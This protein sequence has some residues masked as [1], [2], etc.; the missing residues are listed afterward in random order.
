MSDKPAIVTDH[1]VLRY[2]ERRHGLDVEALR[3]HLA[4]LTVNAVRLG[5]AAVT[6]ENIKLVLAETRD[7]QGSTSVVTAIPPSWPSRRG[8]GE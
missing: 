6:V 2:L 8:R 7:A 4:G 5:A 3:L 1:A